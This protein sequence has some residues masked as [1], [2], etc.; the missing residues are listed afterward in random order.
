MPSRW[1]RKRIS[2]P[3]TIKNLGNG[4]WLLE[5]D[6]INRL[7]SRTDFRDE[8]KVMQFAI[9]LKRLG[10]DDALREKGIKEHDSVFINDYVFEFSDME[11]E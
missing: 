4:Q 10:V 2:E 6:E 7:F 9:A 3:F 8:Q 11:E 1:K 5:G